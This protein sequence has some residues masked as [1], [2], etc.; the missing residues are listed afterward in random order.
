M[1][2]YEK[3][4]IYRITNNDYNKFYIGST[5]ESL[6]QRMA[7]HRRNYN[8]YLN[9]KQKYSTVVSLFNEYGLENC[10]IELI[11][12]YPCNSKEELLKREGYFIASM[13]CVNRCQSGRTTKEYKE[14][15]NPLNQEKIK[16]GLKEWY[17]RTKEER[18]PKLQ[19][20]RDEHK[21]EQREYMKQYREKG[22]E[23][24]EKKK[25]QYQKTKEERS[26]KIECDV[27]GELIRNNGMNKH[28]TT[29]KCQS[30]N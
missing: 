23:L 14:F 13:E 18:Q 9:D 7:N 19:K 29:K 5:C 3:G 10:K 21:E 26:K 24:K 6:S 12:N 20:Y 30:H 2:R 25:E 11:E 1:N 16:T 8:H 28:Q 15:Y 22:E 17:E 27:C 4:K